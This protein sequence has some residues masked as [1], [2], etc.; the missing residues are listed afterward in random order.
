MR[1]SPTDVNTEH[2]GVD[3]VEET[4]PVQIFS[5]G[6]SRTSPR[7]IRHDARLYAAMPKLRKD[8]RSFG[9]GLCAREDRHQKCPTDVG[10]LVAG[11]F[12][13][14]LEQ[15]TDTVTQWPHSII[16]ALAVES[17][18]VLKHLRFVDLS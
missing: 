3:L 7:G 12:D 17:H 5:P 18:G 2:D 6:C 14:V 16:L 9:V 13:M 4:M 8:A 10:K 15:F 11:E 1:L